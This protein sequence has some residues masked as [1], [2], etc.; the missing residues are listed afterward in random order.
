MNKAYIMG[1]V[2][3]LKSGDTPY[4]VCYYCFKR[5]LSGRKGEDFK[6]LVPL[7]EKIDYSGGKLIKPVFFTHIPWR[8][9]D[10]SLLFEIS[11]P[12]SIKELRF[13]RGEVKRYIRK[14][15]TKGATDWRSIRD[16]MDSHPEV[17]EFPVYYKR[18]YRECKREVW[19][20]LGVAFRRNE[21]RSTVRY[22]LFN[23]EHDII[24][25]VES[26]AAVY[27]EK[28]YGVV[29]IGGLHEILED[30]NEVWTDDVGYIPQGK[31]YFDLIPSQIQMGS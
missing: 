6:Q 16:W 2:Y 4:I 7:L 25:R 24:R 29:H 5:N 15:F 8:T 28:C 18:S 14:Y 1:A 31:W 26:C 23:G 3:E 11:V 19:L 10:N 17:T 21:K 22:F 12:E 27:S 30:K 20:L 13:T 9:R